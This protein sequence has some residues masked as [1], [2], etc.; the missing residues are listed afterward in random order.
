MRRAR[1]EVPT[2]HDEDEDDMITGDVV[3]D[4]VEQDAG[5]RELKESRARGPHVLAFL[6]INFATHLSFLSTRA[7]NQSL[8]SLRVFQ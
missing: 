7:L 2:R 8:T 1:Q 3:N 5:R 4:D 6:A